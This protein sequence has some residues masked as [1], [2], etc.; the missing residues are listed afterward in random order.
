ME[1][2]Y[3]RIDV[4]MYDGSEDPPHDV[5]P[6]KQGEIWMVPHHPIALDRHIDWRHHKREDHVYIPLC[7][8]LLPADPDLALGFMLQLGMRA[9]TD[10]QQKL[11]RIHLAIGHPVNEVFQEGMG[12]VWQYQVGI[13][14]RIK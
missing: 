14:L 4:P 6:R 7:P 8:Y 3:N 1:F 5:I 13:A 10:L 2:T 11:Q 9:A 12:N